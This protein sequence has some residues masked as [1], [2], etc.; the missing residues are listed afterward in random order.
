M[1][2]TAL[3]PSCPNF[4]ITFMYVTVTIVRDASNC[5]FFVGGV[6][7]LLVIV[8]RVWLVYR[9]S[10]PLSSFYIVKLKGFGS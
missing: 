10:I 9:L 5:F 8:V 3:K 7:V 6:E 1:L 4:L 2:Y